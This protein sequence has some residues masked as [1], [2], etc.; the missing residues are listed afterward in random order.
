[1][2]GGDGKKCSKL[3]RKNMGS[4]ISQRDLELSV[5]AL[6][7]NFD[8]D[9]GI[10]RDRNVGGHIEGGVRPVRGLCDV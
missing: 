1:L 5:T 3:V 9:Q 4:E 6:N 2:V 10:Q 8:G 7:Y